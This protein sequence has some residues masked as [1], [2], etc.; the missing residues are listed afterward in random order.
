MDRLDIGAV[1]MTR[2]TRDLQVEITRLNRLI[3]R[4]E[5]KPQ[6]EWAVWSSTLHDLMEEREVL[7]LVMLNRRIEAT[8]KVV[9]F[10]RWRDG[11]W[12]A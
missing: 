4:I 12:A 5:A 7:G 8:K 2:T 3:A 1:R 6:N 9:S 10:R 11:P